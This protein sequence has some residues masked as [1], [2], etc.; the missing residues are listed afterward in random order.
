LITHPH[1]YRVN[2]QTAPKK[3]W[4]EEGFDFWGYDASGYSR[5]GFNKEGFNK[6]GLHQNGTYFNYGNFAS[7]GFNREGFDSEG[8][9]R[10]GYDQEGFDRD[11]FDKTGYNREGFDRDGLDMNGY[12]KEGFN[13]DGYNREGFNRQGFNIQGF[14]HNGF[15]VFGFDKNGYDKNGYNREGEQYVDPDIAPLIDEHNMTYEDLKWQLNEAEQ[16]IEL[17]KIDAAN[18]MLHT[19]V[20]LYA[21]ALH[22]RLDTAESFD[23]STSA[24]LVFLHS[25]DQLTNDALKVCNSVLEMA[26]HSL[27]RGKHERTSNSV[28]TKQ[29]CT[30]LKQLVEYAFT[31]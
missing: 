22:R 25:Q 9:N 14:D 4:D 8:F 30:M 31:H 12:D 28:D 26:Q 15:D 7:D 23:I 16:L 2:E 5:T 18:C 11:G 3:V 29:A 13:K 24:L 21:D 10:G 27:Q 20:T 6:Q 17:G 1:H 19:A